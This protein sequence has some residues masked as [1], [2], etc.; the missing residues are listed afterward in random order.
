MIDKT[1]LWST[2]GHITNAFFTKNANFAPLF[3][4]G[5]DLFVLCSNEFNDLRTYKD[6]AKNWF[7]P[8]VAQL[9]EI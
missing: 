7:R 5:E 9:R 3:G 2:I 6:Q 4:H 8:T 1:T